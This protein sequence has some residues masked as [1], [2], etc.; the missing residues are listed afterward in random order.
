MV[1]NNQELK[2]IIQAPISIDMKI[3]LI[4]QLHY[5]DVQEAVNKER[6]L[7]SKGIETVFSIERA[8]VTPDLEDNVDPFLLD[9]LMLRKKT[10]LTI[11]YLQRTFKI[12]YN[13]ANRLLAQCEQ[14]M[15]GKE[16]E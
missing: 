15:N 9:A 6:K 3:D 12:G 14:V 10:K 5:Q 16:E 4:E 1:F 11:L 7:I 8:N 13:R 2:K